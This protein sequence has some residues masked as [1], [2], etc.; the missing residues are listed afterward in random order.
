MKKIITKLSE[1]YGICPYGVSGMEIIEG[2]KQIAVFTKGKTRLQ[3]WEAAI[4]YAEGN[5][6]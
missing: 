6:D 2:N 4:R 1:K 5:H 3:N